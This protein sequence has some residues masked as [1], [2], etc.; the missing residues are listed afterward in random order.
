MHLYQAADG[1]EVQD[2][3]PAGISPWP[4]C[5][6]LLSRVTRPMLYETGN[7]PV[8]GHRRRGVLVCELCSSLRSS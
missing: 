7:K 2:E 4:P 5:Q 1:M 3:R 6:D 8:R